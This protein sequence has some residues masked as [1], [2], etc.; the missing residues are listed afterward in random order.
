M[1]DVVKVV[2]L[3]VVGNGEFTV[4]SGCSAITIGQ[5]VDNNLYEIFLAGR[6][7]ESTSVSEVLRQKG[8]LLHGIEPD[9]SGD[10]GDAE[11][12]GL[13]GGVAY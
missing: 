3:S 6:L 10:V 7:L 11:S 5:V 2:G 13:E 4:R 8:N 1:V 9:E 12:F